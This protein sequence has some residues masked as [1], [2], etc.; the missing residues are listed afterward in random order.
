MST[1]PSGVVIGG[2]G[3]VTRAQQRAAVSGGVN[4]SVDSSVPT[5]PLMMDASPITVISPSS[6]EKSELYDS[7]AT[8]SEPELPPSSYVDEDTLLRNE[9]ARLDKELKAVRSEAIRRRVLAKQQ[10]LL[11][12]RAE[13]EGGEGAEL[14]PSPVVGAPSVVA[15]PV[16]LN[17][18]V[19]Q[20]PARPP[21]HLRPRALAFQST[22]GRRAPTA[23]AL[24]YKAAVN[25][26]PDVIPPGPPA[27]APVVVSVEDRRDVNPSTSASAVPAKGKFANKMGKPNPPRTFTGENTSQ[28]ERV[29]RWIAAVNTWMRL[30]EV[31]SDQQIDWARSLVDETSAAGE[32]LGQKDD[33][34]EHLGKHMTWE[35]LQG[36][37]IQHYGQPSGALAMAAEWEALRMG[38]KNADGSETGGKSTWTVAAY[39]AQFLQFMRALTSHSPATSDLLVINRYV[40][41]IRLGYESLW[42]VMLGVQKVLWYETLQEAIEAAH[43]AEAAI[44]VSR[45]EKR[46]ATQSAPSSTQS[47]GGGGGRFRG[48][49]QPTGSLNNVEGTGSE[50]GEG[51]TKGAEGQPAV[52]VFGFR[53]YPTSTYKDGRF[54]LTEPQARLLYNEGRCYRCHQKHPV[55]PNTGPCPNPPCKTAPAP[56]K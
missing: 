32:W 24:L 28:N 29:D 18:G 23:A 17:P 9:E 54:P 10:Q 51:E 45:I 1:T 5:L 44:N 15:L 12:E 53:Y 35:W 36:Q 4:P 20:T 33:E 25:G 39:T 22:V 27:P 2:T 56:L 48:R 40:T 55:G 52:Q 7:E 41:G 49:R 47:T 11:A 43:Q 37:L 21:Y 19:T 26:L 46:S 14:S 8:E 16:V 13:L 31:P 50:E 38:V 30:T 3:P 34:L 6:D 42:K